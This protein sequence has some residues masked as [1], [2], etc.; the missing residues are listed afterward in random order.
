MNAVHGLRVTEC[1]PRQVIRRTPA[2]NTNKSVTTAT[3]VDP[4]NQ[5]REKIL[6]SG[7]H[8]G[9]AKTAASGCYRGHLT[10]LREF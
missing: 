8:F 5:S 3:N 4:A 2:L 1:I 10:P 7:T 9:T 6:T